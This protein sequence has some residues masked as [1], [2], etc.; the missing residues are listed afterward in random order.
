MT[1][2]VVDSHVHFWNTDRLEYPWLEAHP[3]LRRTLLPADYA[4][5]MKG[6]PIEGIVFVEGNPR[7]DQALDEVR[8]IEELALADPR[9]EGIVAY[10]DLLDSSRLPA[11]LDDLSQR[12]LVRGVRHNIQGNPS[13]FALQPAFVDGVLEAGRRDLTFDL[14]ATHD[15]LSDV[16][17][18]AKQ[19][20]GTRLVLD[21]C[22]KPAIR[23]GGWEPW[24]SHICELASLPHVWCKISGL[25][26]EADPTAWRPGDILPYAEHVA[27]CFGAERVM[28]GSDWPVLTLAD[29]ASE[30]YSLTLDLTA[31]WTDDERQRFYSDNARSFYNP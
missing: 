23:A 26:T 20:D 27:T 31:E 15:Q 14:C 13:G 22:G 5:E 28:Y 10:V 18:L 11:T 16:I 9:I 6:V 8:L 24:A 17:A 4:E 7:P 19:T 29:R 1:Q 3:P 2:P 25:L 12:P 21:H 30:W